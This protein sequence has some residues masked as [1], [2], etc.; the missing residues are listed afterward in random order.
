MN[1]P[2]PSSFTPYGIDDFQYAHILIN[3]TVAQCSVLDLHGTILW[4][5]KSA[6]E[7]LHNLTGHYGLQT[8]SEF[9][10]PQLLDGVIEQIQRVARTEQM[11]R[12]VTQTNL[13][14]KSLRDVLYYVQIFPL[15][16]CRDAQGDIIAVGQVVLPLD[17]IFDQVTGLQEQCH[18]TA[19]DSCRQLSLAV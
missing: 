2:Q 7:A 10:P 11:E 14:S 8:A 16:N 6:R 12:F 4:M 13:M 17:S 5:S 19:D 9:V 3:N 1:Q 15:A 18:H